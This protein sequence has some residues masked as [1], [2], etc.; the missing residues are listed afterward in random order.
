MVLLLYG[1]AARVSLYY[2]LNGQWPCIVYNT[3]RQY[4]Y[5]IYRIV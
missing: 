2:T 4:K 3:Y 5:V 1:A